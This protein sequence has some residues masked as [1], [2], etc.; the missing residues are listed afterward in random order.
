MKPKQ[1]LQRLVCALKVFCLQVIGHSNFSSIRATT[2]VYKGKG[3]LA[4][5]APLFEGVLPLNCVC[6]S[7]GKWAYEVLISSQGLMQIGWCT[8]SC[9]FNQEVCVLEPALCVHT[10][11]CYLFSNEVSGSLCTHLPCENQQSL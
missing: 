11:I 6:G 4:R 2:C 1:V 7:A 9:R 10:C 3:V 8:L 5:V